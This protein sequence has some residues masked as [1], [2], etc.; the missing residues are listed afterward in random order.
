MTVSGAI[1][2]IVTAR[3]SGYA[4][5]QDVLNGMCRKSAILAV[6]AE[7]ALGRA[8][9]RMAPQ[10]GKAATSS[11]QKAHIEGEQRQQHSR[12][13]SCRHRGQNERPALHD[14]AAM[15]VLLC[16]VQHCGARSA[17]GGAA[18]S[19][20]RWGQPRRRPSCSPATGPAGTARVH[21]ASEVR[22]LAHLGLHAADATVFDTCSLLKDS[23]VVFAGG[24]HGADAPHPPSF[25]R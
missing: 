18:A 15:L 2:C 17:S 16:S 23:T 9:P 22:R 25:G 5:C 14:W 20:V 13:Q 7:A 1:A 10:P 3:Q 4:W 11:R 8:M 12:T 6:C 19:G 24:Q 21:P